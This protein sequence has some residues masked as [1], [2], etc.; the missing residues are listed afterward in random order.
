MNFG[1]PIITPN[2]HK[3]FLFFIL[4][5]C[6][7]MAFASSENQK[8]LYEKLGKEWDGLIFECSPYCRFVTEKIGQDFFPSVEDLNL[9]KSK[10]KFIE[11]NDPLYPLLSEQ[12][13]QSENKSQAL[14]SQNQKA[15]EV[16][17]QTLNVQ[18]LPPNYTKVP[19][20]FGWSIQSGPIF[21][22]EQISTDTEIQ[23]NVGATSVQSLF[24][25]KADFSKGKPIH[26]FNEWYRIHAYYQMAQGLSYP[27][28]EKSLKISKKESELTFYFWWLKESFQ[29]APAY[30]FRTSS[31]VSS[32]DT[33]S[34]YSYIRNDHFLRLAYKYDKRWNFEFDYLLSSEVSDSQ[35]YR[36]SPVEVSGYK[37]SVFYCSKTLSVF[38]L[39]FG[40]CG[41]GSYSKDT[42]KTAI[43]S[44][45]S[46]GGSSTINAGRFDIML[47]VRIGE[48]FYQ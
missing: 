3:G 27:V 33:L 38:D 40:L 25:V 13:N 6:S 35:S 22:S 9:N 34:H 19:Y 36:E 37:L 23:K 24:G 10:L 7:L 41:T 18:I 32:T 47:M 45:F 31:L 43:N 20:D 11:K 12:K 4:S 48:D 29:L 28:D 17:E 39:E 42:Q 14:S 16:P 1:I 5:L 2:K 8:F 15:S 46:T 21:S 26:L 44:G 30:I